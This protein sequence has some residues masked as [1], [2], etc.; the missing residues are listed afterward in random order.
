[1]GKLMD[2]YVGPNVNYPV[3]FTK[4]LNLHRA[5]STQPED[6]SFDTPNTVDENIPPWLTINMS[7]D[8]LH[9]ID[10]FRNAGFKDNMIVYIPVRWVDRTE[11]VYYREARIFGWP[12]RL[13]EYVDT[14]V[15][16][17]EVKERPG[18]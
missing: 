3:T 6:M 15:V 5:F 7:K 2:R 16:G 13:N 11:R 14:A 4:P 12:L 18:K 8:I 1:M 10:K 17:I 9:T